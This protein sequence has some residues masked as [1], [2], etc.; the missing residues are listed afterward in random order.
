MHHVYTPFRTF[1]V[2]ATALIVACSGEPLAP[3]GPPPVTQLANH[4]S[5]EVAVSTLDGLYTAINDPSNAGKHIELAAGTYILDGSRPHGGRIELQK[6]M[7]LSGQRG[8]KTAVVIEAANLSTAALTDGTLVTGAVRMGRGSNTVE[9]LTIRN[10][11]KGAG[12]ITTDLLLPGATTVTIAHVIAT[13]NVH[14]FDIRNVGVAAAGRS[15]EVVL[16]DNE[17]AHNVTA[18][19]QGIRVANLP[20][21][22]GAHIHAVLSGNYVHGNIAGCLGANQ[23]TLSASVHIESTGDR[24]EE[25][26]NGVVLLGGLASATAVATGNVT[27]FSALL[28]RFEH[29][30][31]LLS[32][33]F[34][35]RYG[36]GANG[37]VTTSAFS[38]SGNRVELDLHSIEAGDNGGPDVAAWGA[39]S[40]TAVPAGSGNLVSVLLRGSSREAT[41]NA[42]NSDPVE[43]GSTNQVTIV[44]AH[45]F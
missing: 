9:W 45:S 5:L 26:G 25:N 27:R 28:S 12:A 30:T 33:I 24:F 19:G 10:A 34:P 8:D 41:V 18:T 11:A 39:L 21:A 37:G 20:G 14:G 44:R 42:I 31:G 2:A 13:G 35:A 40:S 43:P 17:L 32:A 7:T 6:D 1:M 29:N 38:A 22:N 4:A 16:T 3:G 15:L 36:I 23:G